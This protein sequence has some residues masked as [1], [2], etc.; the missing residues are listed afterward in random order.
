MRY[1]GKYNETLGCE[2]KQN[3][4]NYLSSD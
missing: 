1:K 3:F 2:F 4:K